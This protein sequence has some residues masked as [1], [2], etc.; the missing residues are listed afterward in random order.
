MKRQQVDKVKKLDVKAFDQ[1]LKTMVDEGMLDADLDGAIV[2][3]N[4]IE[5]ATLTKAEF[6]RFY[7]T[8]K[9]ASH[10]KALNEAR[11]KIEA[12]EDSFGRFLQRI[13]EKSELSKQDVARLLNK[14]SSYIE[15][16]ENGRI[17][18]LNLS[19]PDVA[20][21]MQLFRLTVSELK[22]GIKAFLSLS[23]VKKGKISGMA[24]SSIKAGTKG[25]ED[26]L[27]HAMDATLQA[28]A[29]KTGQAQPDKIKIDPDYLEAV[30]EEL[31]KRGE[32][33]LLV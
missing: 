17:T 2:S 5:P 28:I 6:E 7:Q 15:K 27:A 33:N 4:E 3:E 31:K 25:K 14:D 10:E 12:R 8:A 29:E 20:D 30:K 16:I 9:K 26:S 13:R 22:T 1:E 18:P 24:R 19:P 11:G 21:I 23:T 32:E